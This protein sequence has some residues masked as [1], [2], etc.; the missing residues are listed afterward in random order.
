MLA[1]KQTVKKL[2][3]PRRRAVGAAGCRWSDSQ[4]IE[5]VTTYILLGGNCR[6]TANTLKISETT[7]HYWKSQEWWKEVSD[8][9]KTQEKLTLSTKLKKLVDKSLDLVQDRL[10]NGDFIYDQKTG[11]I[12]RKPVV[13][14]DVHKVASDLLDRKTKLDAIDTFKASQESIDDKLSKLAE[15]FK[16]IAEQNKKSV[17][18]TDVIFVEET[19]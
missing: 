15:S 10:E 13:L 9:I 12:K 5:A 4:K 18:V 8:E 7:L 11:Q 17:E 1:D 3:S 6:L 14:K 2:P 16:T 19:K